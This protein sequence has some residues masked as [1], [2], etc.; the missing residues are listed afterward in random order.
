M[1]GQSTLSTP[2]GWDNPPRMRQSGNRVERKTLS[3]PGTKQD[4]DDVVFLLSP[5]IK[6]SLLRGYLSSHA[7]SLSAA[8]SL[9]DCLVPTAATPLSRADG[10]VGFIPSNMQAVYVLCSSSET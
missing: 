3:F 6:E 9:F 8:A 5:A 4:N 1:R 7:H 10:R 2:M